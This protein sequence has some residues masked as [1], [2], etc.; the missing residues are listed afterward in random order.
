M[1]LIDALRREADFG[2]AQE[3]EAA[4]GRRV[5]LGLETGVGAELIGGIPEAFFQRSVGNV[6]F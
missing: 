2:K 3:D 6:L 4:D 1:Q 5:F